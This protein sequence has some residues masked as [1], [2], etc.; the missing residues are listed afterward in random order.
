MVQ[1][2]GWYTVY[3]DTQDTHINTDTFKLTDVFDGNWRPWRTDSF[4]VGSF[5]QMYNSPGIQEVVWKDS[6]TFPEV[7]LFYVQ[8]SQEE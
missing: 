1:M 2:E 3:N 5:L 6:S 8:I 7:V 4:V